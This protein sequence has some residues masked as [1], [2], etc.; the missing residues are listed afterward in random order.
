MIKRIYKVENS[1]QHC[2]IEDVRKDE[3]FE[4]NH[5]LY[6]KI[7]DNPLVYYN[8]SKGRQTCLPSTRVVKCTEINIE[9]KVDFYNLL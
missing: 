3:F 9:Y 8:L 1:T 4:Y 6:V 2:N 5:E 7:S